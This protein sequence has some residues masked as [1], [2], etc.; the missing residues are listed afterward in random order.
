MDLCSA[1]RVLCKIINDTHRATGLRRLLR[2]TVAERNAVPGGG[3]LAV[4]L[5]TAE[6]A[7]KSHKIRP[8][9]S[10]CPPARC[11]KVLTD[12]RCGG[13]VPHPHRSRPPKQQLEAHK[14]LKSH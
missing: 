7:P 3:A 11:I 4:S 2:R 6:E 8:A 9:R 12:V 10:Y 13:C 14:K 1:E 5:A